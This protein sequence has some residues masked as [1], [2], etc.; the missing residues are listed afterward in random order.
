VEESPILHAVAVGKSSIKIFATDCA[1][2]EQ[3]GKEEEFFTHT[4]V[5]VERFFSPQVSVIK[6]D[7]SAV[8]FEGRGGLVLR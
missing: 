8:S 6:L 2:Y 7:F 3:R 4:Q 5:S 1:C